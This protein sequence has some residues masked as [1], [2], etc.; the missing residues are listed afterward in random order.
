MS[1]ASLRHL[2]FPASQPQDPWASS[3]HQGRNFTF[4]FLSSLVVLCSMCDLVPQPGIE[5]V[6]TALEAQSLNHW[7]PRK[8]NHLC[9]PGQPLNTLLA[10][11]PLITHGFPHANSNRQ[12]KIKKV[13]LGCPSHLP[14]AQQSRAPHG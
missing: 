8:L 6:A 11:Q 4:F 9:R 14:S 7:T 1:T 5:P 2:L 13:I 3:Q 12:N 10:P